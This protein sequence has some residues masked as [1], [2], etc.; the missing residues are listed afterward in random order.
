MPDRSP[1]HNRLPRTF[2]TSFKPERHYISAMLRY[3]A[4]GNAGTYEEI[5]DATGIPTGAGSGKVQA[6]LDYG[7]GM[8]LLTLA[9]DARSAVKR[10]EL[11]PFGRV[12]LL[13]DPYLKE[14]VTQW[15]AHFN[16]CSPLTGADAWYHTFMVGTQVLGM[17]FARTKLEEHLSLVYGTQRSGLIGPLVGMYEDEASFAL[18]GALRVDGSMVARTPAPIENEFGY[19][20]GAW[21][22]QLMSTHF[23]KA[24]QV[25]V[26][27]L[28]A[29]AGW[30]TIP[31]WDIPGLQRVLRLVERKGLIDVDR[32]MDPWI[33]RGRHA[34]AES[35][36]KVFD[37]LI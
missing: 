6:V 2:H 11:T 8:G 5:R 12:V 32:H 1:A 17:K 28:D 9:G 30:R 15:L 4:G 10:P 24:H 13:E 3:A 22:L 34:A 26:T 23:P 33:L 19:G 20:Y 36:K 29:Q 21:M 27:E 35:W 25:T 7:R 18:C 31:G 37:D 16:L 14:R